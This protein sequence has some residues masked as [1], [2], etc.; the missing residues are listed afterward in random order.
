MRIAVISDSHGNKSG[1]NKIFESV[2]FDYLFFLGDG[3]GDLG[4]YIYLDNVYAVSGNCDFFSSYPN[5]RIIELAG[6]KLL[7]THGNRYGVKGGINNLLEYAH[8]QG[9]D[10]VLFGHTHKQ[11]AEERQ[12]LFVANPGTF[13]RNSDGESRGLIINID[14][15]DISIET[16]I[17]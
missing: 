14:E 7:I 3:L 9:V 1:I 4:N 15:D 12:G 17:V 5:E 6:K 8:T 13:K 2:Q 10:I 16:L 11:I